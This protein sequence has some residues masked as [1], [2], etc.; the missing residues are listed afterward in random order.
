VPQPL[1]ESPFLPIPNALS[2]W[3]VKHGALHAV[4][5]FLR[6]MSSIR[7]WPPARALIMVVFAFRVLS[8]RGWLNVCF[9]LGVG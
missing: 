2:S 6:S 4:R 3:M 7:R 8:S 9:P 1:D 5:S